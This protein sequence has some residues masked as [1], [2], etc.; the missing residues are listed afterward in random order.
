MAGRNLAGR[1]NSQLPSVVPGIVLLNVMNVIICVP[2][3]SNPGHMLEGCMETCASVR[4]EN[5]YCNDM[6][7]NYIV[8]TSVA[9]YIIV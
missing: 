1:M 4:T 3:W 2:V 9:H 5:K 7:S 6:A 8:K